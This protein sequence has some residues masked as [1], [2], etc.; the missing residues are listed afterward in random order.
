MLSSP[1][2]INYRINEYQVFQARPFVTSH[3]ENSVSQLFREV[4]T[5]L[6]LPGGHE[7]LPEGLRARIS[8]RIFEAAFPRGFVEEEETFCGLRVH[9]GRCR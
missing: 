6:S 8:H 2:L 7:A 9:R 3:I 1:P 4:V 5:R